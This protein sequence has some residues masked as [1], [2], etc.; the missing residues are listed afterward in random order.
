MKVVNQ[1]MNLPTRDEICIFVENSISNKQYNEKIIFELPRI[2]IERVKKKLPFNMIGYRCSISS[3]AVRHIKKGHPN[4][5][6]YICEVVDILE[7]F[8][9]VEKSLIRC[10]KTRGT[11]VHLV[12]YKKFEDNIVKLVKLKINKQKVLELKTLFVKD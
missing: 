6:K 1:L 9:K 5:L 4:D 7:N 10:N 8:S 12:F 2:T 11:L 3:H